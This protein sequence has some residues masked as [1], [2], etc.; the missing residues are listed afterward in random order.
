MK[1]L[2]M[3]PRMHQEWNMFSPSVIRYEKWVIADVEFE[4][5]EVISLFFQQNKDMENHFN[6]K[7]F[8]PYNNQFWRKLF[9]RLGKS[10]YQKHIPKFKDWLK[11]TD[12]FPEYSDRKVD[13]VKLWQLSE[14]SSDLDTPPSKRPKVTKRELKKKEKGARKSRKSSPKKNQK[15]QSIN[16]L[17]LK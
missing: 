2:L 11:K 10:S 13:K 1:R 12:Y 8:Q 6:R 3:Y 16:K 4:N 17:K 7:Y 14:K 5:G 9:G 15:K